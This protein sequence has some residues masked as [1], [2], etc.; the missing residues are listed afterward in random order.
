[1]SRAYNL[2]KRAPRDLQRT[3]D[4]ATS[5]RGTVIKYYLIS[6]D[7]FGTARINMGWQLFRNEKRAIKSAELWVTEGRNLRS[8]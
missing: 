2:A 1:M 4:I 3:Y 8:N 5:E 7:L 6:P